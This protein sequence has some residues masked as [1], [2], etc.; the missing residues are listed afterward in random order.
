MSSP[1][2]ILFIPSTAAVVENAQQLPVVHQYTIHKDIRSVLNTQLH[3]LHVKL[4]C[5]LSDETITFSVFSYN[6]LQILKV[7]RETEHFSIFSKDSFE[8]SNHKR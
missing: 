8:N 6:N 5:L 3:V 7:K 1:V 4:V 2:T